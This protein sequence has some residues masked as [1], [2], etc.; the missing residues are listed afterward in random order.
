MEIF[1]VEKLGL[2]ILDPLG[3]SERLALWAMPISA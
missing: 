1:D 2:P 3:T